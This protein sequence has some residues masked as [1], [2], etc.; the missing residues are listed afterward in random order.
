MKSLWFTLALVVFV[1]ISGVLLRFAIDVFDVFPTARAVWLAL[2]AILSFIVIFTVR[3][4]LRA[5]S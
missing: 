3:K 5:T 1:G 2:L 4:A